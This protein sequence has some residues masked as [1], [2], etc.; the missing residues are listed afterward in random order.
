MGVRIF[1]ILG[2]HDRA[3]RLGTVP[4]AVRRPVL[5]GLSP[6]GMGVKVVVEG[7][8]RVL[9][10]VAVQRVRGRFRKMIAMHHCLYPLYSRYRN[11][12]A[13]RK[14][15][16]APTGRM[17]GEMTMRARRSLAIM[18]AAPSTSDAGSRKR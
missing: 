18:M 10:H 1:H 16:I 14:L 3:R 4:V 5:M 2:L 13:P 17:T 6:A 7:S 8:V 11:S 15:V 9:V 12:G